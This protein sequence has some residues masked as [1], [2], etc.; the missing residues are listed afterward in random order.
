[1]LLLKVEFTET[2]ADVR[3][4]KLGFV[5]RAGHLLDWFEFDWPLETSCELSAIWWHGV[6]LRLLEI[7]D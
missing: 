3:L 2:V 1:M 6:G 7:G 4:D 5:F